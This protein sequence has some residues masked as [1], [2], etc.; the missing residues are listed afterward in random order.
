MVHIP[1]EKPWKKRLIA[2]IDIFRYSAYLPMVI[3][4]YETHQ[5]SME[6]SRV[7]S[8]AYDIVTKCL[9]PVSHELFLLSVSDL[10]MGI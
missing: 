2:Q 10:Q 6:G 3:S 4:D 9:L 5:N 7:G 1:P 8:I